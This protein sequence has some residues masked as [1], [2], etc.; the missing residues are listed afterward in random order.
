MV[1]LRDKLNPAEN[2][3]MNNETAMP[4]SKQIAKKTAVSYSYVIKN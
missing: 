2:K 3:P 4:G 1:A